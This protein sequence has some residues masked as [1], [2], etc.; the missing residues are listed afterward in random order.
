MHRFTKKD[1]DNLEGKKEYAEFLNRLLTSLK[2]S[3]Q[4]QTGTIG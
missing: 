2:A 4:K 3:A 1:L